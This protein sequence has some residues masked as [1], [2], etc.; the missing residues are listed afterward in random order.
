MTTSP[1]CF[2]STPFLRKGV[3]R[4]RCRL[5]AFPLRNEGG[6]RGMCFCFFRTSNKEVNLDA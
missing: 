3:K 6:S 2:A 4:A 1:R 5:L